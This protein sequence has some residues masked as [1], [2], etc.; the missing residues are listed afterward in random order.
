MHIDSQRQVVRNIL[1]NLC[2]LLRRVGKR[3]QACVDRIVCVNT[4]DYCMGNM[5]GKMCLLTGNKE[6]G[7]QNKSNQRNNC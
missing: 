1:V 3:L 2:G 5:K 4:E 7:K 6:G